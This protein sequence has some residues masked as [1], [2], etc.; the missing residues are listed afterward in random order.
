M[1]TL[2]S[3]LYVR[4]PTQFFQTLVACLN[5]NF[6]LDF[7]LSPVLFRNQNW[8]RDLFVLFFTIQHSLLT[9]LFIT[10]FI[11]EKSELFASF[12]A[13]ANFFLL[14]LQK[15]IFS[16][17]NNSKSKLWIT[18][19][20]TKDLKKNERRNHGIEDTKRKTQSKIEKKFGLKEESK[21]KWLSR[22]FLYFVSCKVQGE[23]HLLK[24]FFDLFF[25]WREFAWYFL[26]FWG[27]DLFNSKEICGFR[28][29]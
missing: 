17:K 4:I 15:K 7:F 12:I 18:N 3:L 27:K 11:F 5:V 22:E 10:I 8:N 24:W 21:I 16:L 6:Q 13:I 25:W 2:I 26:P 1:H 23:L 14:V 29:F 28:V 9:I 19:D 20:S